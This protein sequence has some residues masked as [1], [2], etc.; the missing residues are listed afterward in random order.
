MIAFSI[1]LLV[2]T[3]LFSGR[4]NASSFKINYTFFILLY[5]S[6][7]T[8]ISIF[9]FFLWK[10]LHRIIYDKFK[11]G[12]IDTFYDVNNDTATFLKKNYNIKTELYIIADKRME[13]ATANIN[14]QSLYVYIDKNL[15]DSIKNSNKK[16][17]FLILHEYGHIKNKDNTKKFTILMI[18]IYLPILSL[19]S[20]G[21][22]LPN[23]TLISI[24]SISFIYELLT[25]STSRFSSHFEIR[26]DKV[27]YKILKDK[28]GAI[29]TLQ[30]VYNSL[31]ADKKIRS[32]YI[33]KA[34]NKF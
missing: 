9:L 10:N 18:A 8:V 13:T 34:T 20:F 5:S 24:V 7:F 33:I 22:T 2:G 23:Y 19:L 12:A 17:S 3:I 32:K 16:I 28:K 29:L 15:Y 25:I 6:I 11:L 4:L 21:F 1:S 30:N 14:G 31:F 27:S 26:A